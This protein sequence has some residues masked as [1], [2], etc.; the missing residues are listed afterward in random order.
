M[1][2]EPTPL[3]PITLA[4]VAPIE[5]VTMSFPDAIQEIINGNRVARISWRPAKDYGLFKDDWLTVFTKDNFSVWKVNGGD[6]LGQ[7]W[8]IVKKSK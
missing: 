4:P 3:T 5:V 1:V 8:A 7:D 6:L 2:N